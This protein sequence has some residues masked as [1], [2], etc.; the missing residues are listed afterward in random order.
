MVGQRLARVQR[1]GVKVCLP[2][3]HLGHLRA[4]GVVA[5]RDTGRRGVMLRLPLQPWV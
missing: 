4:T 1:G 3:G 5:L 2:S